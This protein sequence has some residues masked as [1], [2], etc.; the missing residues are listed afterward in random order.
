M[1]SKRKSHPSTKRYTITHVIH[2]DSGR[3]I[4]R[5]RT[6]EW[7]TM[8]GALNAAERLAVWVGE[9][10]EDEGVTH[11]SFIITDETGKFRTVRC[12]AISQLP[13]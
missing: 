6:Q 2:L 11:N 9:R 13:R 5:H 8:R 7:K 4:V 12:S 1:T 3:Q 10:H